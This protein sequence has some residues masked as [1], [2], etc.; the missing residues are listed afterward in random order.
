LDIS[1][2]FQPA[3]IPST[4]RPFEM[5]STD[6]ISLA[7]VIGSRWITRQMP[8]PRRIRFVTAAQAPN[9]TNGSCVCE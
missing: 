7:S 6:A 9:A 3:P 4:K 2:R 1:S 8:V 5:L